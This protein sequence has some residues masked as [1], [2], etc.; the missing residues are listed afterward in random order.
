MPVSVLLLR[1]RCRCTNWLHTLWLQN[2]GTWKDHLLPLLSFKSAIQ[3]T[4]IEQIYDNNNNLALHFNAIT[5][6]PFCLCA[7]IKIFQSI[8][9]C[10]VLWT[11]QCSFIYNIN[12][13]IK[14]ILCKKMNISLEIIRTCMK[15]F[16][17]FSTV[18]IS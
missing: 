12:Y 8:T 1:E 11:E 14:W 7:V 3:W 9:N 10:F 2:N 15:I 5:V 17:E 6:C 13:G 4:Q 18:N 16:C